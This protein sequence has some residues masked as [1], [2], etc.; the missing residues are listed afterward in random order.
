MVDLMRLFS[1]E[2]VEVKS[3]ISNDYWKHD[4]EDNAYAIMKDTKGRIA[5]FNSTATQWQH[6]FNLEISLTDGY[7]ELH[8]ILSGSKSY[9]E[10]KIVI[11]KRNEESNDGQM[12]TK[13]IKFLQDNSWRDEIFEFADAVVN[14]GKI[15]FGS[16]QDALDTMKLVYSIYYNDSE[17]RNKYQINNPNEVNN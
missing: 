6:K 9:G 16:S 14:N 2:F 8:G 5:M 13:T 11:G 1:G 10:E 17:W 15:E 3:F 4:V 7:I 12:E